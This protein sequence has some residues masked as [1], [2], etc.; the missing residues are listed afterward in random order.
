MHPTTTDLDQ[1]IAEGTPIVRWLTRHPT[2]Q[3]GLGGWWWHPDETTARAAAGAAGTVWILAQ[4][5]AVQAFDPNRAHRLAAQTPAQP[6]VVDA[7]P[8]SG[9]GEGERMGGTATG[10]LSGPTPD[11][12][13]DHCPRSKRADDPTAHSWRWDGDDPRIECAYCGQLRDA[14]TGHV[15]RNGRDG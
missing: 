14:L 12:D 3:L 5:E 8:R 1:L 4:P 7:Q 6:A 11:A 13:P 2:D 9:P 15:Y 10:E